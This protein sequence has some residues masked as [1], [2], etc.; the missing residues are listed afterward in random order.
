MSLVTAGYAYAEDLQPTSSSSN[1]EETDGSLDD[2][3]PTFSHSLSRELSEV[4]CSAPSSLLG[5]KLIDIA[6]ED[7]GCDG[8]GRGEVVVPVNENE[9]VKDTIDVVVAARPARPFLPAALPPIQ[10]QPVPT[11]VAPT[12]SREPERTNQSH[13]EP[14][15]IW[16]YENEETQQHPT[17]QRHPSIIDKVCACSCFNT[18]GIRAT[19]FLTR[20]FT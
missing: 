19:P 12:P 5:V 2:E 4:R 6:E 7:L 14:D 17:L 11:P 1:S 10:K 8:L 3:S 16:Y 20:P 13:D 18:Q 9:P 15:I